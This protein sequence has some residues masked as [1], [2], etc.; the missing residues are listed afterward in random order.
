MAV[1]DFFHM[2]RH[3]DAVSEC[4]PFVWILCLWVTTTEAAAFLVLHKLAYTAH[5]Q[6]E[7]GPDA[8][9]S[10]RLTRLRRMVTWSD[11][12]VEVSFKEALRHDSS[13]S[14]SCA[15]ARVDMSCSPA[16]T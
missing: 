11:C 16:S 15:A 14:K 4:L 2:L 7:Q 13:A 8:G 3:N 6:R 12:C 1:E 10:W 5:C 9:V